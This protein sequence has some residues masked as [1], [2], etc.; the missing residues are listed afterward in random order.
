MT[1]THLFTNLST[2]NVDKFLILV[3]LLPLFFI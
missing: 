3:R 1:S 2:V